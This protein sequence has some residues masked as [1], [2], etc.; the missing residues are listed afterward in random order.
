MSSSSSSSDDD[1]ENVEMINSH[2]QE[3]LAKHSAIENNNLQSSQVIHGGS[4][5]GRS[6]I[7]RD[8]ESAH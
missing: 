8:R 4:V 3:E 7:H 1:A 5:P 6:F 2:E